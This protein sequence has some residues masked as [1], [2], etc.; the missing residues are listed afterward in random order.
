MSTRE[1]MHHFISPEQLCIGLFIHLDLSWMDHPFTF[2]SFKIKSEEQIRTLQ[3]LGLEKI[4]YSPVKSDRSP[5]ASLQQIAQTEQIEQADKTADASLSPEELSS[6]HAK[7]QRYEHR[8][9]QLA[10]IAACEKDFIQAARTVRGLDRAIF[11]RPHD[12]AQAGE[13][14]ILRLVDSLMTDKDIAIH[15]MNDRVSGEDLYYH[16]L[17][18]TLLSMILAKES[19]L[20]REQITTLGMAALFHDTGKIEIPDRIL[21]KEEPLNRS[22]QALYEQHVEWSLNAGNKAGLSAETL[23]S[24]AQHHEL[25]DGSGFPRRLK[26]NEISILSRALAVA[27]RFDYLCNHPILSASLTPHEALSRIFTQERNQYDATLLKVFVRCMG[28]YPPGSIVMLS[29]DSYATV[30]SVNSTRPLKPQLLV[31]LPDSDPAEFPL[32]DLE[33]ESELNISK[34][35]KPSQLPREVLEALNPRKRMA[36]YFAPKDMD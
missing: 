19:K 4:R 8:K 3:R 28:V 22:E 24:I 2:S 14:L 36:Y 11:S 7:H 10:L 9:K 20:S 27:D 32:I 34:S 26:Q 17:N 13:R 25:C 21:L 23:V 29:N 18:V 6:I 5:L 1:E 16:S 31:H 12:S 33:T 15:L 35:L 30:I